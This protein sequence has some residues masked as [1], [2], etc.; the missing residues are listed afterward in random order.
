MRDLRKLPDV[1]LHVVS[2][3]RQLQT[4]TIDSDASAAFCLKSPDTAKNSLQDILRWKMES[5]IS[6]WRRV[7]ATCRI[8]IISA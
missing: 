1:D 2:F 8:F 3:C 4:C 7:F 5:K 6:S